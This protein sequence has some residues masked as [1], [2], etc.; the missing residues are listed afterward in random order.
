MLGYFK[1]KEGNKEEDGTKEEFEE[2][3]NIDEVQT[4]DVLINTYLNSV[5]FE[6]ANNILDVNPED[7]KIKKLNSISVVFTFNKV[8]YCENIKKRSDYINA[9]RV[10]GIERKRM[11]YLYNR[12]K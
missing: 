11:A 7:E 6:D 5:I 9:N 3:E 12:W 8:R 10:K 2:L 1:E 4:D